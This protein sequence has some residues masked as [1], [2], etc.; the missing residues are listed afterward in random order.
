ME[1]STPTSPRKNYTLQVAQEEVVI[2]KIEGR[3]SK[4]LIRIKTNTSQLDQ[5]KDL[6]DDNLPLCVIGS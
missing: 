4:K 1:A 2:E 5:L 3:H 6:L